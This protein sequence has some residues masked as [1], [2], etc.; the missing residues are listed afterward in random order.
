VN[1]HTYDRTAGEH[2]DSRGRAPCSATHV[3][4]VF[5]WSKIKP[6]QKPFL[7]VGRQPTVLSD[8][9][10]KSFTTNLDIQI[11]LKIL[12]VGIVVTCGWHWDDVIHLGL[13]SD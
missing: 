8:I 6:L 11:G 3:K 9:L 13:R 5:P 10:A 12:I 2:R 1:I 7:L 4:Q